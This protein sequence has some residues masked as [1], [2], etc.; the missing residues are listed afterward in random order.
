M[1]VFLLVRL[2]SGTEIV[3]VRVSPAILAAIFA[4]AATIDDALPA[5][6]A[7]YKAETL[8]SIHVIQIL[9]LLPIL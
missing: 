1:T 4:G 5:E 8:A 7:K 3:I 2:V 9:A 6:I